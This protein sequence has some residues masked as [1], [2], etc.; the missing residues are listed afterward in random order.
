MELNEKIARLIFE[1]LNMGDWEQ[2]NPELK[3]RYLTLS[4]EVILEAKKLNDA[5]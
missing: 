2:T 4:D 1:R 5:P 3:K